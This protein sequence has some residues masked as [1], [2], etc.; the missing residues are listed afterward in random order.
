MNSQRIHNLIQYKFRRRHLRNN[1]TDAEIV[2]WSR[3]KI[4]NWAASSAVSMVLATI[5]LFFI[6]LKPKLV[7]EVDGSHHYEK[8]QHEYDE[9]RGQ[10]LSN[11]GLTILRFSNREVLKNIEG[12]IGRISNHIS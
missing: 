10:E 9:I 8:K 3:L 11:L 7:I 1:M 12:A 4:S 6:V 5:L 2:L